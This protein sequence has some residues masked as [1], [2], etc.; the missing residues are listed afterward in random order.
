MLGQQQ[1]SNVKHPL[2]ETEHFKNCE[3]EIIK[4]FCHYSRQEQ[5]Y[6]FNHHLTRRVESIAGLMILFGVLVLSFAAATTNLI[7][8]IK[9]EDS[10][11]LSTSIIWLD[12]VNSIFVAMLVVQAFTV[13]KVKEY[14]SKNKTWTEIEDHFGSVRKEVLGACHVTSAITFIW[15][16][17]LLLAMIVYNNSVYVL[18]ASHA[19]VWGIILFAASYSSNR[20]YGYT[21][22]FMRNG[23]YATKLEVLYKQFISG[24]ESIDKVMAKLAEIAI[25]AK[26]QTYKDTV[27]DYIEVN[28]SITK[29]LSSKKVK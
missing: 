10:P 22:A 25:E 6:R 19:L 23:F 1:N 21:R 7:E 4:L 12:V 3:S 18:V 13:E 16:G 11:W 24:S 8:N 5:N 28:N 20:K 17:F 27:N 15:M 29:W 26:A 2:K 14:K 9:P